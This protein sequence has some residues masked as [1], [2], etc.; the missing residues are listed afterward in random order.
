MPD[1]FEATIEAGRLSLD[2]SQSIPPSG[3]MHSPP[4]AFYQVLRLHQLVSIRLEE[5]LGP[6]SL[7]ATQYTMLS[8]VRRLQPVTSAR[9]ARWLQVSAQSAGE[10]LKALEARGLL[11][12][13][14]SAS[15]KRIV[16]LSLTEDGTRML[17][18]ADDLV[19]TAE[20]QFFSVLDTAE[21]TTFDQ[22]VQRLR[23]AAE[24]PQKP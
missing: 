4:R 7:T 11:Q 10:T 18:H 2:N 13:G 14:V 17:A 3:P 9:L 1:I 19:F 24:P 21:R 12:R 16:L 8:L 15:N 22:A 20:N 5:V 23:H 6:A